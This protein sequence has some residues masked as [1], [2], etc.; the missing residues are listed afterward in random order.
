MRSSLLLQFTKDRISK[1]R[2]TKL[3]LSLLRWPCLYACLDS[4]TS[5]DF[6]TV[7]GNNGLSGGLLKLKGSLLQSQDTILETGTQLSFLTLSPLNE[8][9][10]DA[11]PNSQLLLLSPDIHSSLIPSH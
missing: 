2:A 1:F 8:A 3:H 6:F 11:S 9:H 5:A 4:Q 7:N 10:D